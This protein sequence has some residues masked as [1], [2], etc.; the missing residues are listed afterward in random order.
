MIS[1]SYQAKKETA[2]LDVLGQDEALSELS[3]LIRASGEIQ[4]AK[5]GKK[6]II[7]TEIKELCDKIDKLLTLLY[8][9]K[10]TVT[11]CE[12]L[13]FSK[14]Q[15]Y[16]LEFP[17]DITNQLLLD[18][19]IMYYDE[20]KYLCHNPNI[21]K[22]LVQEENLAKSY[23]RGVFE[24]CFTCNIS[25]TEQTSLAKSTG[26]HAEFV[27]NSESIAQDFGLLLADFDIISK[28]VERKGLFV[29]YIKD[30]EM[31]CDLFVLVGATKSALGL[32]N[33][34]VLRSLRNTANRQTNCISA[35]L[36]KTVDASLKEVEAIKTIQEMIGLETLSAS[37]LS[38]ANLRLANPEESLE[39]LVKLSTEKISKSG[40]YHRLKKLEQI[41]K[42][43]K[44]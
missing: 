6:V 22:Y 41:A 10:T 14:N 20:D 15:R 5:T 24:G 16:V 17:A 39:N 43:L 1:F 32:Q 38:V 7:K 36:T 4:L 13:A 37:L 34:N 19:E 29:V 31:I 25:L 2:L 21:S 44:Q 8:G 23:I 40:L 30:F 3:A 26:Y 33:E 12:E 11:T 18:T 27:F 42:E 9:K 35:N 28:M